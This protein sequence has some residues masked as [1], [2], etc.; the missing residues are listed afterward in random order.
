MRHLSAS[1]DGH[2]LRKR[3]FHRKSRRG[4]GNC[5]LRRVKCDETRPE[6]NNCRYYQILCSYC[7]EAGSLHMSKEV[8]TPVRA[9]SADNVGWLDLDS[10]SATALRRFGARTAATILDVDQNDLMERAFLNPYLMHAI[11]AVTA[12]HDRYHGS[13][14]TADHP[15]R[16]A[17]YSSQG[18]A[19]LNQKLSEPTLPQDRDTLWMTA[20]FLGIVVFSSNISES[21]ETSWPLKV[22]EPTDLEWLRMTEAKRVIWEL[23]DTLQSNGIFR[24][25]AEDFRQMYTPLPTTPIKGAP[26]TLLRIC[27]LGPSSSA[28]DNP[29]Y[30]A[31]RTLVPLLSIESRKPSKGNILCFLSQMQPEFRALLYQR[32]PVALLILALWYEKSRHHVWWIWHRATVEYQAI[33]LYLRRLYWDNAG[34]LELLP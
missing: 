33:A 7:S 19:L 26:A 5:K 29:Y 30:T 6:C 28:A 2:G 27:H 23:A 14:I 20:T 18:A 11:L 4:C 1:G 22:S 31:V 21:P 32:D 24:N 8:V 16:E 15:R 3:K 25:M 12:I 9:I 17:Y 34:I 13:P 10:E